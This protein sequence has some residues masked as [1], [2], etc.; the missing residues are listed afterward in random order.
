MLYSISNE[1]ELAAWRAFKDVCSNL[2]ETINQTTTRKLWKDSSLYEAVGC[3][4]SL[5]IH[6]FPQKSP[7]S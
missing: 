4:M 3:N 1:T 7:C 2:L 6:F 5:N